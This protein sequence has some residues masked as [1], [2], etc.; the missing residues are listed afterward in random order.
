MTKGGA[1]F[2]FGGV[3]ASRL[4]SSYHQKWLITS[5]GD[6]RITL[7][8]TDSPVSNTVGIIFCTIGSFSVVASWSRGMILA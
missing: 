8:L 2:D 1:L 4:G 3:P 7:R 5:A 6:G